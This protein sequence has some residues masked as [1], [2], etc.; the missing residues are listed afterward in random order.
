MLYTGLNDSSTIS[1]EGSYGCDENPSLLYQLRQFLEVQCT[2][3]NY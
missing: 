3:L 2:L 1:R